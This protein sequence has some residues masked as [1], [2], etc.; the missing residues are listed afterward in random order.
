LINGCVY[1]KR[2]NG[3]VD[4]ETIVGRVAHEFSVPEFACPEQMDEPLDLG[5]VHFL[6]GKLQAGDAAPEFEV[7]KLSG[8]GT[9][10][11]DD[12]RGKFLLLNFYNAYILTKKRGQLE[13]IQQVQSRF[14]SRSDLAIVGIYLESTGVGYLTE[15]LLQE[16][17]LSVPHGMAGQYDSKIVIDYSVENLPYSVLIGPAGEVLAKGLKGQDLV[18]AVREV[19]SR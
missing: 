4:Y 7:P 11:L 12:Y 6:A 2:P 5:D 9:I 8:S 18:Q 19:L 1:A 17:A 16:R 14:R 10:R 3:R 13:G 15:K